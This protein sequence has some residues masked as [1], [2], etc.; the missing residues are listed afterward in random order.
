M[1]TLSSY[2]CLLETTS[3]IH[4]LVSVATDGAP[5]MTSEQTDL[6]LFTRIIST[7]STLYTRIFSVRISK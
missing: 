1:E 7:L 6:T 4:K 3:P 2:F 5:D